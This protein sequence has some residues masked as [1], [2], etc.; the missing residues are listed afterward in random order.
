MYRRLIRGPLRAMKEQWIELDPIPKKPSLYME[1]LR[2]NLSG[3]QDLA[4]RNLSKAQDKM[5]KWFNQKTRNWE[6]QEGDK[7]LL[8]SPNREKLLSERFRGPYTVARKIKSMNY[9][10]NTPER[11]K[12]TQVCHMNRIKICGSS[13]PTYLR[14][15]K[16]KWRS[17][18]KWLKR[19]KKTHL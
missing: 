3:A 9:K 5:K 16:Q 6:F 7:V 18:G 2:E 13:E 15:K 4:Q 12:K 8:L 10:V 11:K 14:D 17:R 1:W 19:R